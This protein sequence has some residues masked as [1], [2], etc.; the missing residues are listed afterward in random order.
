M[1]ESGGLERASSRDGSTIEV[2]PTEIQVELR[3]LTPQRR[4]GSPA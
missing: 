1:K 4:V 2:G 3:D